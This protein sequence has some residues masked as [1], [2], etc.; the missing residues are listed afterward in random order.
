MWLNRSEEEVMR[1]TPRKVQ[2]L[3]KVHYEVLKQRSGKSSTKSSAPT[4]FI[5]E[6]P[7]W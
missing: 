6:I 5:D 7:G 4:G 1:M 3:L 2:A